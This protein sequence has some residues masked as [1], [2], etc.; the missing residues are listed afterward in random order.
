MNNKLKLIFAFLIF[1][2]LVYAATQTKFY[3]DILMLSHK[4]TGLTMDLSDNTSA[5]TKGYVD[6]NIWNSTINKL[7]LSGGTM[8]GSVNM[9]G[10]RVYGLPTP[11]YPSDSAT[12]AYVDNALING[13]EGYQYFAMRNGSNY[14]PLRNYNTS[15][16]NYWATFVVLKQFKGKPKVWAENCDCMATNHDSRLSKIWRVGETFNAELYPDPSAYANTNG[17]IMIDA[18]NGVVGNF[19]FTFPPRTSPPPP[20][21]FKMY[22]D[23]EAYGENTPVNVYGMFNNGNMTIGITNTTS[24]SA[25]LAIAFSRAKL[26]V[27]DTTRA[28]K[29]LSGADTWTAPSD[30]SATTNGPISV[31]AKAC[32]WITLNLPGYEEGYGGMRWSFKISPDGNTWYNFG[33]LYSPEE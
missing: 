30:G 21:T 12:K 2:G 15:L 23:D 33:Q 7:P 17:T 9:N 25:T 22:I 6:T 11:S 18:G 14:I 27:N 16:T 26:Y 19:G 10:K 32:E 29:V 20:P 1:S 31:S 24:T 4:I 13:V 8:A 5:S 3:G 28:T